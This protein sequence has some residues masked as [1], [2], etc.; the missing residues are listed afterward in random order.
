MRQRICYDTLYF[1]IKRVRTDDIAMIFV[2]G[3]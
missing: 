3:Q 2:K 1:Y